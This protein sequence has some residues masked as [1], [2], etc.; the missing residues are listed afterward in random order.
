MTKQIIATVGSKEIT[1]DDL[2]IALQH[3]PKNQAMQFNTPEG[4]K[5]L[6]SEMIT[7]EMLYLDAKD[8]GL[9]RNEDFLKEVE[10]M[11]EN[12][13]KQ[14]AIN[15]LLK[16]VTV[17]EVEV[18][19]YYDQHPEQFVAEES[20]RA[21]HILANDEATAKMI[22]DEIHGGK[23]FEDAATQYSEC[24]SRAQGGDLGHFERG[25]MV[26][27]FE[28]A[29][30]ALEVGA[31]S[32][33]VKTQFGYHIIKVEERKGPQTIAFDEVKGQIQDY[34][35]RNKQ[36]QLYREYTN[37]L[38]NQYEIVINEELLK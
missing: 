11:K 5:Y 31:I 36:N 8:K 38:K 35:L 16:D 32:D 21:R 28:E 37:Q 6:L 24:P 18:K 20:M 7:Q 22:L 1:K 30:F 13:L 29:A 4:R 17:S 23:S 12:L 2:N 9:D 10:T 26:P 27:E 3:A 33:L 19:A 25:K 14:Y 34:L 15:Y